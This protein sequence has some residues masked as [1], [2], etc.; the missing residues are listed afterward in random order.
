MS[1]NYNRFELK[2][3]KKALA[4]GTITADE[5]SKFSKKTVNKLA[6]NDKDLIEKFGSKDAKKQFNEA[7]EEINAKIE[8]GN[9]SM[10]T[11][12][13]SIGNANF[14]KIEPVAYAKGGK[15]E[16]PS[17]INGPGV[18]TILGGKEFVVKAEYAE[19]NEPILNA[20]NSGAEFD[21]GGMKS[22]P[23]EPVRMASGGKP[24]DKIEPS[25]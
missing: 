25:K 10:E 2:K 8:S 17:D 16:G 13:F 22:M 20:M 6:K 11:G 5:M 12:E 24:V 9:F 7:I 1:D 15:V 21:F 4:D 3:L 23:V 14:G 19:K 18:P